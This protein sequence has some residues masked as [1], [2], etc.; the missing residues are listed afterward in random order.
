MDPTKTNFLT[1]S[2][3]GASFLR[4]QHIL[5]RQTF[6][7]SLRVPTPSLGTPQIDPPKANFLNDLI[8]GARVFLYQ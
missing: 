1:G 8:Y 2:N 3:K 6:G 5:N 4:Y 7:H